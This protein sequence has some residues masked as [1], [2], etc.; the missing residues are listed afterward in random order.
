MFFFMKKRWITWINCEKLINLRFPF[1]QKKFVILWCKFSCKNKIVQNRKK[2]KNV[3][4]IF[5]IFNL[6]KNW[7]I[8]KWTKV[9]LF[10]F[11]K[12]CKTCPI[13][14]VFTQLLFVSSKYLPFYYIKFYDSYFYYYYDWTVRLRYLYSSDID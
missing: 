10:I 1:R 12:I 5:F 7:I 3:H 9:E 13:I 4:L 8:N 11:Q 2:Q 14:S 6:E